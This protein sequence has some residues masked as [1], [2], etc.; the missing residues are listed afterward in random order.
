MDSEVL[1]S[2]ADWTAWRL[3]L[4][5]NRV[6]NG[7]IRPNINWVAISW[8]YHVPSG[9]ARTLLLLLLK[10]HLLVLLI[11]VLGGLKSLP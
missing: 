11:V 8:V 7:R 1:A 3:Q 5:I 2:F 6:A 9:E 10:I 4:L